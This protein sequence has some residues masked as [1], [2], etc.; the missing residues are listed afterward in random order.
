MADGK[1]AI[2]QALKRLEEKGYLIREQIR[3]AEG[4]MAENTWQV[5]DTPVNRADTGRIESVNKSEAA[6]KTE[7]EEN[8]AGKKESGEDIRREK[9]VSVSGGLKKTAEQI[10]RFFQKREAKRKKRRK[11]GKEACQSK[12]K[13]KKSC[14]CKEKQEPDKPLINDDS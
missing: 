7:R 12:R 6:E 3:N 2:G 9:K 5:Y 10:R 4:K 8:Q 1:Y 14:L 11:A 13:Q